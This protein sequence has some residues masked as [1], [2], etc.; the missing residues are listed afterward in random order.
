MSIA[1]PLYVDLDMSE[2]LGAA[3]GIDPGPIQR[4]IERLEFTTISAPA[5]VAGV[6]V[7]DLVSVA[8]AVR[9]NPLAEM[10]DVV[11]HL[12]GG[13]QWDPSDQRVPRE[14]VEV[15]DA[16]AVELE[17]SPII[18]GLITTTAGLT[19]VLALRRTVVTSPKL[20]DLRF[21]Q[22]TVLGKVAEVV[23]EGTAWSLTG[24]NFMTHVLDDSIRDLANGMRAFSP[25]GNYPLNTQ[26]DGPAVLIH[27]LALIV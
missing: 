4:L 16:L 7:G 23:G 3:L 2:G 21:G 6:S 14:T 13:A 18:E 26:L 9:R 15:A 20:E 27:P 1:Y 19:G 25:H 8:G 5:D 24:R 22:V 11:R 17:A 10:V 12:L